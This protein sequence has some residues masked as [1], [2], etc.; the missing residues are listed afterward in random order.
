MGYSNKM[1]SIFHIFHTDMVK[2]PLSQPNLNGSVMNPDPDWFQRLRAISV[3]FIEKFTQQ[4]KWKRHIEYSLRDKGS[5][6]K[7][8]A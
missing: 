2:R 7:E 6:V 8:A 5:G 4:V 3:K 1:L